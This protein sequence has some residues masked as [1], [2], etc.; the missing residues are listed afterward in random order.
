MVRIVPKSNPN[1]LVGTIDTQ[2]ASWTRV[3][4]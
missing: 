1:M 4:S 3:T 2:N